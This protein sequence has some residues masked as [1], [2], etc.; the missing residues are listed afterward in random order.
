MIATD[1][2][3]KWLD[4]DSGSDEIIAAAEVSAVAIAER[5]TGRYLGPTQSVV[6]VLDGS[7]FERVWLDDPP[8]SVSEVATRA[9]L[10]SSWE[11]LEAG[12]YEVHDRALVRIDGRV[13]PRGAH[14]IRVT[15]SRGFSEGGEPADIRQL[16]RDLVKI[17]FRD[18]RKVPLEDLQIDGLSR[19]PGVAEIVA[20]Y[21]RPL[22]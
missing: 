15:C 10:A 13:W 18:G 6:F 19:Q 11:V 20:R 4:A 17:L 12:T 5:L 9:T 3:R 1:D 22:V 16:V 8:A 21:R 2:L 7:G 14:L